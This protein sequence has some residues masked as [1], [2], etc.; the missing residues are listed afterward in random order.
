MLSVSQR[1]ETSMKSIK[2]SIVLV[3]IAFVG[4]SILSGCTSKPSDSEI[5][6]L[7]KA[8]FQRE[9]PESWMGGG[10]VIDCRNA[11]INTI[12]IMEWGD[13][14]KEEKYWPIKIRVAGSA[15]VRT[16]TN[17]GGVR[18]F[19][20]VSEFMFSKDDYGKWQGRLISR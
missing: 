1:K 17:Q 20:K 3:V 12:K 14:N 10:G 6:E 16:V 18:P 13:F 4:L 15:E 19:N 5:E 2:Q 9:V 11:K 8:K 7:V